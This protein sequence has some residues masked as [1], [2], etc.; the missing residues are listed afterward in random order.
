MSEITRRRLSGQAK[1]SPLAT[2]ARLLCEDPAW[3]VPAKILLDRHASDR[4][5]HLAVCVEPFLDLILSGTKTVESRFSAVRFPPYGC[6]SRGDL[7]LLK[8]SGGPVVGVCEIG[9]AWFY[10]LD[11]DSWKTIRREFARALCAQD[12]DFWRD[13]AS[14]EFATLMYVSRAKRLTPVNWPKRD[15]RGWV[16]VRSGTHMPLFG[17]S[18]KNTVLA[19]AGGIASGKSTLS[20]A[21]AQSLGCPRVTFG[22]YVRTEAKR[23]G[24]SDDRKTLQRIGE[25]LVAQDAE[26]VC[27]AVLA[28][29]A[30][31]P[32]SALV[33]DGVRHVNIV[34]LLRRLVA[35]SGFRLVHVS[36]SE[37]ARSR[38]LVSRGGNKSELR[39]LDT[40]STEKDVPDRLRE[41]A[42]LR[43]DGENPLEAVIDEVSRW[44]SA[45][46]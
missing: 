24:V 45:L 35:P 33:V 22:G 38:R 32:G 30:W 19:F 10:H 2:I 15:R 23:R 26:G 43:V 9:A 40:H 5:V 34:D 4:S 36:A 8:Q 20:Q 7:V 29:A 6:V 3:S 12:P 1:A 42:D 39:T 31:L 14:A 46:P 25:E 44:A 11:K 37:Q 16:V 28:Q 17:G 41:L 21:V 18:M 13:R 27:R